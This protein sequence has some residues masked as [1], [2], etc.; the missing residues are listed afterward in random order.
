MINYY[1]KLLETPEDDHQFLGFVNLFVGSDYE[2][3]DIL[4]PEKTFLV[5]L[6]PS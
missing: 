5:F 3:K 6:I 1:E 4:K 2:D